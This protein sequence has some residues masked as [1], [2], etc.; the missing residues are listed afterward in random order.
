MKDQIDF[1]EISRLAGLKVE[2]NPLNAGKGIDAFEEAEASLKKL[3]LLVICG[4]GIENSIGLQ[5]ALLT[6]INCGKRAFQGGV[7]VNVNAIP[8]LKLG[9]KPFMSQSLSEVVYA[10][11]GTILE[12]NTPS[13]F[14]FTIYIGEKPQNENSIELICTDWQGG[15]L[16]LGDN[17]E[18]E[19]N[20][21]FP[22]GG[23]LS[24]SIGVAS[25]FLKVSGE[26]P[27]ACF[28]SKGLSLWNPKLDWKSNDSNGPKIE[29]LPQKFWLVG[30]GHLGQAY[31]WTLGLLPFANPKSVTVLLQ[32]FDKVTKSNYDSGL[33]TEE[34]NVGHMK[35]RVVSNWL[36]S[37]GIKTL[38]VER[39]FDSCS[40]PINDEPRILLRGLDN[41]KSRRDIEVK[42]FDQVID[43]GIGGTRGDFD[44]ITI[45][46]LPHFNCDLSEI[47]PGNEVGVTNQIIE[48]VMSK[49][50]CGFYGKAISTSFVGVFASTIVISEAIKSGLSGTK[51]QQASFSL[52]DLTECFIQKDNVYAA[53]NASNGFVDAINYGNVQSEK[54]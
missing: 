6:T 10:L 41:N 16:T 46:N 9:W 1:N 23:I 45:F 31:A 5:A 14:S 32:D 40:K 48:N 12:T 20:A 47:W 7:S 42:C 28:S 25:A 8:G 36:E 11:G 44:S 38:I 33:L 15:F 2:Q 37:N 29:L 54:I 27:D 39:P 34:K 21:N 35:T 49:H 18:I 3:R 13:E 17:W 43:C 52:R 51:L 26:K 19:N 50:G 30:L 4:K 22:L 24:A 53:E